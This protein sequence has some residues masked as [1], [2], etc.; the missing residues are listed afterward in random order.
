MNIEYLEI[1]ISM[2]YREVLSFMF[3]LI[4]LVRELE[5]SVSC[6]KSFYTVK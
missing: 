4:Y 2:Q 6:G 3:P 5:V 1:D